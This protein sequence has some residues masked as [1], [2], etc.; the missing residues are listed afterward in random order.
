M[1]NSPFPLCKGLA[2]ANFAGCGALPEHYAPWFIA[3]F[4]MFVSLRI[5]ATRAYA[6]FSVYHGSSYPRTVACLPRLTEQDLDIRWPNL[7][8]LRPMRL[9]TA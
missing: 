4:I 6:T 1:S 9:N 3:G 5:M 8:L 2:P 7:P